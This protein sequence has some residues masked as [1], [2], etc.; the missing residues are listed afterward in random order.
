[1]DKRSPAGASPRRPRR[2][3]TVSPRVM[4][5][6]IVTEEPESVPRGCA[7]ALRKRSALTFQRARVGGDGHGRPTG[8]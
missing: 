8:R 5:T 3:R 6:H 7:I 4:S 2:V 1:M